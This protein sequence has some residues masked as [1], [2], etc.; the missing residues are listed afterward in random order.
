MKTEC[1]K[2]E[3]NVG[4]IGKYVV[5]EYWRLVRYD[6]SIL[7]RETG[8]MFGTNCRLDEDYDSMLRVKSTLEA[9]YV[10]EYGAGILCVGGIKNVSIWTCFEIG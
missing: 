9:F 1:D 8:E 2:F 6:C 10:D 4:V 3:Q 5:I 7:C